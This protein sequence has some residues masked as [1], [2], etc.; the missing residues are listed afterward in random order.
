MDSTKIPE[1]LFYTLAGFLPALITGLV[2]YY[3]FRMHTANEEGRRRYL[4]HK[5]GQKNAMPIRLQ[6]YERLVLFLER[7]DPLKLLIRVAPQ[8]SDKTYYENYLISQIEQEY[9]HNLTQQIYVS[10]ESWDI[11]TTA[12]NATIQLIRKSNMSEKVDSANRLR[13]VMLTDLFD[14]QSPSSVAVAYLKNEVAEMW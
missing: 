2:A 12:K 11:I 13:E 9:E 8:S 6:A 4:I 3:F 5:E 7:I 10:A 14:K 1:I